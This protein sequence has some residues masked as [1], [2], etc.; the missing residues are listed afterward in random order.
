MVARARARVAYLCNRGANR[1]SLI[2]L[3]LHGA[4]H[5]SNIT[6]NI[7]GHGPSSLRRH[8]TPWA[9]HPTEFWSDRTK[10]IRDTKDGSRVGTPA[11]NLR[12]NEP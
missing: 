4:L 5:S 6:S 1:P 8:E 7:V 2:T 9:K 12:R 3:P 10:E 11:N